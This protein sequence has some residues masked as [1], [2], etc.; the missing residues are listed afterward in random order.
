[1]SAILTHPLTYIRDHAAPHSLDV[2]RVAQWSSRHEIL[3]GHDTTAD[4]VATAH[5]ALGAG[6]TPESV[7]RADAILRAL[8]QEHLDGDTE[9]TLACLLV[10]Y[11]ML[12]SQVG[13]AEEDLAT[14]LVAAVIKA[15]PSA[16][17]SAG[18]AFIH[19][20][21]VTLEARRCATSR[22]RAADRS[23]TPAG[24]ASQVCD[25]ALPMGAE[26]R[27]AIEHTRTAMWDLLLDA[28][29]AGT[30]SLDDARLLLEVYGLDPELTEGIA[31]AAERRGVTNAA[32]RQRLS[33]TTR[34]LRAGLDSG[35]LVFDAN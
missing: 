16:L 1:M 13:R 29:R 6:S 18:G 14:E 24:S 35:M 7:R 4:L 31:A 20:R 27:V 11:P 30:I 9:A 28:R 26:R 25:Y 33:R 8:I 5:Q 19:L 23:T 15:L 34:R 10:L 3:T 22:R 21:H 32:L 12:A 2:E 17:T